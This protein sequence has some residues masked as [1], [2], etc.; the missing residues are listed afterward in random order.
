LDRVVSEGDPDAVRENAQ[1]YLG[2]RTEL[3]P[4]G[5]MMIDRVIPG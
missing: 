4:S 3:S 1:P 5:D 2:A